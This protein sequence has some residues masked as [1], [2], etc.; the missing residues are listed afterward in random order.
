MAEGLAVK[1]DLILSKLSK[2][3]KLDNIGVRF[4]NITT[5]VS[6]IGKSVI[7]LERDVSVLDSKF[8]N[9]DHLGRE[10]KESLNSCEGVMSKR[11]LRPERGPLIDS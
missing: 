1:V 5:T 10:L 3:D 9:T 8:R 7:K 2:P 4:N 6:S 11:R